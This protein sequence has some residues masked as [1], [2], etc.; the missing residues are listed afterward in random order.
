DAYEQ[1]HPP[2][3]V[4]A[5]RARL[6]AV[7]ALA[8]GGR[9][10]VLFSLDGRLAHLA[11]QDLH[12][13]APQ[14]AIAVVR[15]GVAAWRAQGLPLTPAAAP[16][17]REARIDFLFW[18]HD[19]RRGNAESMRAYLAWERQLLAQASREPG[20]FPL[21]GGPAHEELA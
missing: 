21:A 8:R 20:G 4:W 18:A 17:A 3:A 14:A 16:L 10:V 5:S 9:A 2:G 12:E 15:G 13:A 19:R 1:A 11:A 7:A 6:D